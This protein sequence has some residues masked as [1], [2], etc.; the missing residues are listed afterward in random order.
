M[1]SGFPIRITSSSDQELM[2]SLDFEAPGQPNQIAPLHLLNP[3]NS[4][5]Y[6]FDPSAFADASL[7][8]IGNAPRA[9]CC[10]PGI[11]NV[12]FAVHKLIP[13]RDKD[14]LEFRTEFFN[15]FNHTQ[16]LNPDG[17]ITDGSSFGLVQ[18]AR[19]PRLIQLALKFIF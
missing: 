3:R 13:I 1:Q 14:R 7:G 10:G 16:F 4:G 15:V 5:G 6:Y 2:G 12:D 9:L 11:A 8:Q 19:E 18:R 17:D